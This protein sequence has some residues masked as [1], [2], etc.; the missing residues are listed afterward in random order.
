M[1]LA[2]EIKAIADMAR[3]DG[4]SR[5]ADTIER[6]AN[7]VSDDNIG[8]ARDLAGKLITWTNGIGSMFGAFD[9]AILVRET[10]K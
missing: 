4:Q 8:G 1:K 6:I 3:A 2:E 5:A 9:H 10:L 7:M